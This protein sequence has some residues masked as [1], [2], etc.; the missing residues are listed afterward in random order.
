MGGGMFIATIGSCTQ[1][2]GLKQIHVVV[3][4]VAVVVFCQESGAYCGCGWG[5][6]AL[7]LPVR[8]GVSLPVRHLLGRNFLVRSCHAVLVVVLGRRHRRRLR[9]KK[10]GFQCRQH[11]TV[12]KT[13]R[14]W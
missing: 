11:V 6:V 14:E 5:R 4:V 3:V 9:T 8:H 2:D 12:D 13:G 1:K 7:L 10:L